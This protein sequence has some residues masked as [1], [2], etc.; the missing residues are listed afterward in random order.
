MK[1]IL[2]VED[3]EFLI[4]IL[5]DFLIKN[6]F[7]VLEARNGQEGLEIAKQQHPDLILLDI[8]MP[9]MDGITMLKKLREDEWGK[10]AKVI[11]LTNLSSSEALE[12]SNKEHVLEYLIKAEW[13]LEDVVAVVNNELFE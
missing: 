12:S 6:N 13:K 2:I 10:I 1:R 7:E 9:I 11:M 3:Q 5:S 4:K 8:I